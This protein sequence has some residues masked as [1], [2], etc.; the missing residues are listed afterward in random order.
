[1]GLL[2][3]AKLLF[4][5]A[6]IAACLSWRGTSSPAGKTQRQHLGA[7]VLVAAI[8]SGLLMPPLPRFNDQVRSYPP[9]CRGWARREKGLCE[10]TKN[11]L[12][13]VG[14]ALLLVLLAA[15]WIM[16]RPKLTRCIQ[17]A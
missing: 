6:I 8:P 17:S 2:L 10:K 13:L 11:R 15:S 12:I 9:A 5:A 1:M 3:R 7:M 4:I 16:S 14:M